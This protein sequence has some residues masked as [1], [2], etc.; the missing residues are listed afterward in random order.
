MTTDIESEDPTLETDIKC[1][2]FES[3]L[4]TFFERFPLCGAYIAGRQNPTPEATSCLTLHKDIKFYANV[5][6]LLLFL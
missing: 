3:S 6:S 1:I 2:A 4:F 5:V